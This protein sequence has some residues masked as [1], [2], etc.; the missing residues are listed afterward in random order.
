MKSFS[1]ILYILSDDEI[2]LQEYGFKISEYLH[3]RKIFKLKVLVIADEIQEYVRKCGISKA[4]AGTTNVISGSLAFSGII[5]A[6]FT[7]GISLGLSTFG[8]SGAIVSGVTS[9]GIEIAK[10]SKINKMNDEI[11][12]MRGIFEHKESVLEKIF[13]DFKQLSEDLK[14]LEKSKFDN[15]LEKYQIC[16]AVSYGTYTIFGTTAKLLSTSLFAIGGIGLGTWDLLTGISN[17]NKSEV[18]DNLRKFAEEYDTQ[19]NDMS[20]F[21]KSLNQNRENFKL[22]YELRNLKNQ[23]ENRKGL[24]LGEE[25]G[26]T[27]SKVGSIRAQFSDQ[28]HPTSQVSL[29]Y[30]VSPMSCGKNDLTENSSYFSNVSTLIS[31]RDS[32]N[33]TLSSSVW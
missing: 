7:G 17:Q 20:E 25:T 6:P 11:K 27:D 4:V 31:A 1:S 22:D 21:F 32:G 2:F 19:T 18:A 26:A 8:V 28:S 15:L 5:L 29:S 3:D 16:R 23:S 13:N 9:A 10:N 24:D 33:E 12:S 30:T 14:K